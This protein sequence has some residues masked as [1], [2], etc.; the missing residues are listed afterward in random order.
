MKQVEID[1]RKINKY[2]VD[3]SLFVEDA[4][5]DVFGAEKWAQNDNFDEAVGFVD[6]L[7]VHSDYSD[8]SISFHVLSLPE[9]SLKQRVLD[10]ARG[11]T[12]G[13]QYCVARALHECD[14]PES[15]IDYVFSDDE[16]I[17]LKDDKKRSLCS[18]SCRLR[19][20]KG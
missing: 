17:I 20:R 8:N 3:T 2:D 6:G 1:V 7:P 18:H 5:D 11:I 15:V 9:K 12:M 16:S 19:P 13:I 4:W 14:E 10:L